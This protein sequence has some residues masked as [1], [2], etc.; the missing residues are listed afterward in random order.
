MPADEKMSTGRRICFGATL[1]DTGSKRSKYCRWAIAACRVMC[2]LIVSTVIVLV[3]AIITTHIVTYTWPVVEDCAVVRTY[4]MDPMPEPFPLTPGNASNMATTFPL[5]DGEIDWSGVWWIR[6]MEED[7]W[8]VTLYNR[9]YMEIAVSFAGTTVMSTTD[10]GY[11]A[12]MGM[13][14]Q[15]AHHWSYG[16]SFFG[17]W[18]Q[19]PGHALRWDPDNRLKFRCVNK[20]MCHIDGIDA[21]EKIDEDTWLR[22]NM[23]RQYNYRL[24]R[25][26][27]GN[28]TAHPVYYP[29][30]L[31][32][33]RGRSLLSWGNNDPCRR[34][35][36]TIMM[37]LQLWGQSGC[38]VCDRMCN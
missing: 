32:F 37:R 25:I 24:T 15:L 18:M 23:E 21:F 27:Y 4:P 36:E 2:M 29:K 20:T 9:L 38:K 13:P 31:D 10:G 19:M 28:G 17:W 22:P 11:P 34:Y 5:V 7:G 26:V 16:D 3:G 8:A 33:Y 35:C 1:S 12:V 30:F 6:W 14:G